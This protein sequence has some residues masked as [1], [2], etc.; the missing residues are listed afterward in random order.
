M[1]LQIF[2][3]VPLSSLLSIWPVQR[4]TSYPDLLVLVQFL[5]G[6]DRPFS[7]DDAAPKKSRIKILSYADS[8]FL[9][10]KIA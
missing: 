1:A 4:K 7:I 3:A 6:P 10:H 2:F 8:N 9:N 5:V